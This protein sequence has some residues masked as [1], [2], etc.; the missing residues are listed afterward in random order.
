MAKGVARFKRPGVAVLTSSL[1]LCDKFA[2][3]GT[4]VCNSE[5]VFLRWSFRSRAT[6][7]RTIH[8]LLVHIESLS[9]RLVEII[10]PSFNTYGSATGPYTMIG[11]FRL[12]STSST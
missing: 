6:R 1:P 5:L 8:Q 3:E 10:R 12:E 11:Y 2:A 9:C 7:T 4:V